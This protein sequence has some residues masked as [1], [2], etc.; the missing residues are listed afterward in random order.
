MGFLD[1]MF[2]K[3]PRHREVLLEPRKP[4]PVSSRQSD[5][6]LV[7]PGNEEVPPVL[8]EDIPGMLDLGWYYSAEK[9]RWTPSVGQEEG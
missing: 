8:N 9:V 6:A 5:T 1:R 4:Q 3:Q 2:N 7:V